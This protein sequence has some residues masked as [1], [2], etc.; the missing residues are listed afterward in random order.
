MHAEAYLIDLV[1]AV[2]TTTPQSLYDFGIG[3]L[4]AFFVIC[5]PVA[6]ILWTLGWCAREFAFWAAKGFMAL[7]QVARRK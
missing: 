6:D 4:I 2:G 3:L 7:V 1:L 5:L